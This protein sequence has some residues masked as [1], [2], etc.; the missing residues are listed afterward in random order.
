MFTWVDLSGLEWTLVRF[1]QHKNEV[2]TPPK[3]STYTTH[4]PSIDSDS[5]WRRREMTKK[6]SSSDLQ[7][8]LDK[9]SC[10]NSDDLPRWKEAYQKCNK[11]RMFL[12]RNKNI[13]E[14]L[15][16]ELILDYKMMIEQNK[17]L[18]L[19]HTHSRFCISTLEDKRRSMNSMALYLIDTHQSKDLILYLWKWKPKGTEPQWL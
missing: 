7:Q 18:V 8:E 1:K 3:R 10:E 19:V 15:D 11:A 4:E 6:K 17:V 16:T 2:L 5:R 13:I 9:L 14:L 12:K